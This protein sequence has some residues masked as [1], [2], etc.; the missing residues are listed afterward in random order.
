MLYLHIG[1]G[2]AG[3]T[4]VQ[5]FLNEMKSARFPYAQIESFGS[6]SAWKL[7]AATGTENSYKYWVR[8][9]NAFTPSEFEDNKNRV[10]DRARSEVA[11]S[12]ASDFVASSEFILGSFAY[13]ETLL[14]QLR[15]YLIDVFGEVV[16]IVYLREQVS[17]IKSL[18]SQK[19]KG[20]Q[21]SK[22]TLREYVDLLDD[23][24][25]LWDYAGALRAWSEVF[26]DDRLNVVCFHERNLIEGDLLKDFLYRLNITDNPA[27]YI[28]GPS[29]TANKSPYYN[30]LQAI[31]LV[32]QY[33]KV[34]PKPVQNRL[35]RLCLGRLIGS[36]G[37]KEFP[38]NFDAQILSKVSEGNKWVNE[39]FLINASVKLPVGEDD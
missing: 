2:K 13:N 19:V 10:W 3:S 31:R 37:T 15:D 14:S 1:A 17:Y 22:L 11:Q 26:G 7:A 24:K 34:I 5:N 28:R 25:H 30:Q 4:T 27:R 29:E 8:V 39:R 33:R 16:V 23:H 20:P 6:G 38:R 35:Y 21:R 18:Y 32:N 9:R 12:Q 36:I